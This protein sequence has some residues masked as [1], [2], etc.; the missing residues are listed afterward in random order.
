MRKLSFLAV[1][2]VIGLGLSFPVHA[3]VSAH[4]QFQ[5]APVPDAVVCFYP[6]TPGQPLALDASGTDAVRCYP[7]DT[8]LDIPAR[9]FA[10]FMKREPDLI[11]P[12]HSIV[13]GS[14]DPKPGVSRLT[15]ELAPAARVEVPDRESGSRHPTDISFLLGETDRGRP[16]IMP[17]NRNEQSALVPAATPIIPLR[18]DEGRVTAVGELRVLKAGEKWT[19]SL[20]T[21][22]PSVLVTFRGDEPF[23]D[24]RAAATCSLPYS[25]RFLDVLAAEEIPAVRLVDAKGVV[26]ESITRARDASNLFESVYVFSGFSPGDAR[27]D[28]SGRHWLASSVDLTI[29][30]QQSVVV[31]EPLTL[32]LGGDIVVT[33]DLPFGT[34]R[35]PRTCQ[36]SADSE[37]T[38][39]AMVSVLDCS[40]LEEELQPRRS[41]VGKCKTLLT[42]TLAGAD[43]TE[44]NFPG[45]AAREYVVET[46]IGDQPL[47]VS[48]AVVKLGRTESVAVPFTDTFVAGRVTSGGNPVAA[49]VRFSSGSAATEPTTGE[50]FAV[51]SRP[52][53]TGAIH[54]VACDESFAYVRIPSTPVPYGV[55]YDFEVP[56]NEVTIGVR[57]KSSRA[58]IA[59]AFVYLSTIEEEHPDEGLAAVPA[60]L[61]DGQFRVGNVEVGSLIRAC[62]ERKGYKTSCSDP[63]VMKRDKEHL[64]VELLSLGRAGK[65]HIEGYSGVFWSRPNGTVSEYSPID[66][67]GEFFYSQSHEMDHIVLV[68]S[69]PMWVGRAVAE[70]QSGILDLHPAPQP[71]PSVRFALGEANPKSNALILLWVDGRP[72]PV[73][74]FARHQAI[75]R[76][77][78]FIVDRVPVDVPDVGP[79]T[80]LAA[81]AGPDP[82]S[83]VGNVLGFDSDVFTGTKP[84][85]VEGPNVVFP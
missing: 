69:A 42:K 2:V 41:V 52:P 29:P 5:G 59:D 75:R 45:L 76:L 15:F 31:S 85:S 68:G 46:A 43:A 30:R 84:Q 58:A 79:I 55:G 22:R 9:T 64:D 63:I 1:I 14:A 7:A 70:S 57:D 36:E 61:R 34:A 56:N 21:A 4:A 26:H 35:V 74:A 82:Q 65:V 16:T 50:Y 37:S 72:V 32:R 60:E 67:N 28:V 80:S 12:V 11:S 13:Y 38:S 83:S 51:L 19:L 53:G 20:A 10:V 6:V 17:V 62:A 81:A 71:G 54:V 66:E 18:V 24:E 33:V 27:L 25:V 39:R 78:P 47:T 48:R 49:E 40:A 77:R 8:A 23:P 3:R 73:S 44:M